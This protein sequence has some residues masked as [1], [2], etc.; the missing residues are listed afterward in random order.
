MLN[1]SIWWE[2]AQRDIFITA[3]LMAEPHEI[4]EKSPQIEIHTLDFTGWSVPKGWYGFVSAASV[5]I[6]KMADIGREEGLAALEALG[7][8]D[9]ESKSKA[10]EGRRMVRINGGFVILNYMDYRDKDHTGAER[11][12]RW[13]ERQKKK[14]A[15][16]IDKIITNG[17]HPRNDHALDCICEQCA[18]LRPQPE[19]DLR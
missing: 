13:R 12:K 16:K 14:R 3:L 17:F 6:I 4:R 19:E 2:K 1:S 15:P 11:Q 8:P 9:K 7:N 18:A 10:F 5:G